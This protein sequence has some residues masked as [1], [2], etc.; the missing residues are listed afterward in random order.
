[1][2]LLGRCYSHAIGHRYH[3]VRLSGR[4]IAVSLTNCLTCDEANWWKENGGITHKLLV[5]G[6]KDSRE[7]GE[8]HLLAVGHMMRLPGREK[9]ESV[10]H[11]LLVMGWNVIRFPGRKKEGVSLTCCWSWDEMWCDWLAQKGGSLTHLLLVM[12]WNVMRL[13]GREKGGSV[14]HTLL[15]MGWNVM[16]LPSRRNGEVSLTHCLPWDEMQWDCVAEKGGSVTH[17]LWVMGWNVMRLCGR[18]RGECY[19]QAVGNGMK[20]DD[21]PW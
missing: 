19:P 11:I 13:P 9:G 21:V 10:T 4:K 1:M 18:K 7:K 6:W 15:V 8:C 2:G 3:A 12:G 16:T 17:L 14:T 5:M 20:C